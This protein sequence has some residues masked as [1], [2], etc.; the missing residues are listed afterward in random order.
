MGLAAQTATDTVRLTHHYN[1][2]REQVY[3][4]WIDPQALGQ[5]FGPHS[6]NCKVEK[7]DVREGGE[8]RIRMIPVSEDIDCGGSPEEDSVCA[9][10][11]VQVVAP[12]KLVMT[13]TW[14]ENGGDIGDSLLTIELLETDGGTDVVLTHE[15]LPNEEMRKAHS[16]GWQG[17]LECLEEFLQTTNA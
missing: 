1:A 13:F 4:A 2:S 15:R 7:Y 16:G 5:W 6:H 12:E 10:T 9:G 14:I 3:R 8:Y 11:F 17:T